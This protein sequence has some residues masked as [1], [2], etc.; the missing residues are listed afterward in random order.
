MTNGGIIGPKNNIE[1]YR[2]SGLYSLK[3][4]YTANKNDLWEKQI[5]KNGLT[6]WLD[7]DNPNSYP[8]S[9]NTWFDL[10]GNGLDATGSSPI[11]SGSLGDTQ[12]YTTFY[13]AN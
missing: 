5:I 10:S 8:G 4:Q 3:N 2:T 1:P 7:A 9:G 6:L 11:T 12:P 13:D